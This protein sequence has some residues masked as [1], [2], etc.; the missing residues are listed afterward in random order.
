MEWNYLSA[1]IIAGRGPTRFITDWFS[2]PSVQPNTINTRLYS[3]SP[4]LHVFNNQRLS[5]LCLSRIFMSRIFHPCN[6]VPL[7]PFP[8]VST[9][10]FWCRLPMFPFPLFHVSHFSVPV[11]TWSTAS[12]SF[13]LYS[14]TKNRQCYWSSKMADG[15]HLEN[16][17]IAVSQ[18]WYDRSPRKLAWYHTLPL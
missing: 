16:R 9:P 11:L 17:K 6:F 3:R 14:V 8:A 2:G 12:I 4:C 15:R 1:Y 10:A 5:I 7:F 13:N 18:Q